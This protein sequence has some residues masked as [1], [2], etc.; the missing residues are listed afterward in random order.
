MNI[1]SKLTCNNQET[2]A[3]EC[4]HPIHQAMQWI[5]ASTCNWNM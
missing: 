1:P 5:S 4:T 3:A 2:Q